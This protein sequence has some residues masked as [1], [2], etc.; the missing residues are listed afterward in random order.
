MNSVVTEDF[1]DCFSRLPAEVREQARRAYRLWRANPSHPGLRFKPI[2]RHEGL[3][4][5]RVARG[6]RALGRLEG[7]TVTWF[8]I[9]SHADYDGLVG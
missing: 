8:W 4:S 3:Y 1:M 7:D 2:R 5:V 6:W 9:G